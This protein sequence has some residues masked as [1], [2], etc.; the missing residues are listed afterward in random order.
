MITEKRLETI[1]RRLD[2]LE[3]RVPP[4]LGPSLQSR[5]PEGALDELVEALKRSR[6]E[7]GETN[8]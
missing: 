3:E 1:E 6:T 4:K 2:A 7:L 5:L 8:G